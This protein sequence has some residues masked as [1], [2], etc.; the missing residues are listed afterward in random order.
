MLVAPHPLRRLAVIVAGVLAWGAA[1]GTVGWAFSGHE[2][3]TV[4]DMVIMIVTTVAVMFLAMHLA[5]R[6][7]LR[8]VQPILAAATPTTAAITSG[9][10]CAAMRKTTSLKTAVIVA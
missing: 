10:I 2:D 1:M 3:P 5:L 7:K 6:R 9:D 4:G 8:R